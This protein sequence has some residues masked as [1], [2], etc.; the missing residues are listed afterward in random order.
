MWICIGIGR[1]DGRKL[2]TPTSPTDMYCVNDCVWVGMHI[3]SQGQVGTYAQP[4][5][6]VSGVGQGG[7]QAHEAEGIPRLAGDEPHATNDNL[8]DQ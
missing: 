7:G 8:T 3:L 4:V 6:E 2:Y 1:T 5:S